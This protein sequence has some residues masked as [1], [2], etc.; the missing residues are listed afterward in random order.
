MVESEGRIWIDWQNA[1]ESAKVLRF[2][3][4]W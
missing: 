4:G 1:T 2:I 3:A